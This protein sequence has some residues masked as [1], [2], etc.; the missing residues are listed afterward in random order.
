M[1]LMKKITLVLFC[2]LIGN[3][4]LSPIINGQT[5]NNN[6]FSSKQNPVFYKVKKVVDGDTFWIDDGTKKGKKVRFIGIDAPESR[7]TGKKEIGY[8]GAESKLYLIQRLNEKK[9]RLEK[10]VSTLD[11]YRR[12]LAYIYLEDG[13]FLNAELVKKGYAVVYTVPPDVKYASYFLKLQKKARA[14]GKGLWRVRP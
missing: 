11:R 1:I 10:D 12:I 5:P 13:T 7:K 8:F 2:F 4:F 14:K 9:V 3:L 6:V